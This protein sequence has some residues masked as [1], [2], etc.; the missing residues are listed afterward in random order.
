MKV[1]VTPEFKAAY[2][3][4][5]ASL[6][7][8]LLARCAQVT[9]DDLVGLYFA[10]SFAFVDSPVHMARIQAFAQGLHFEGPL[11]VP[12]EASALREEVRAARTARHAKARADEIARLKGELALL[13]AAQAQSPNE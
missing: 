4:R 7:R 8:M 9:N 1:R 2:H 11:V 13:R 10:P 3:A 12:D 6:T 5:P